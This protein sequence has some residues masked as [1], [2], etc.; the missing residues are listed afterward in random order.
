M[1][2]ILDSKQRIMDVFVTNEGR[3]QAAAGEFSIRYATFT[4]RHTFYDTDNGL[5]PRPIASDATNR[6]F[7]ECSNRRQDQIVV[8]TLSGGA[9]KPFRSADFDLTPSNNS[10]DSIA[11]SLLPFS[12]NK[13]F[14]IL[15]S[16]LPLAGSTIKF[17]DKKGKTTTIMFVDRPTED[18]QI[19][20]GGLTVA[21]VASE[22]SKKIKNLAALNA[23]FSSEV[24]D[25]ILIV[26][27]N[28]TPA[29]NFDPTIES[30]TG[31]IEKIFVKQEGS[32]VVFE[33]AGNE[34]IQDIT[35]NFLQQ[36]ILGS[37]DLFS[38]SSDF[39]VN[40][41]DQK[42]T[43]TLSDT[44]PFK[45]NDLK[46]LPLENIESIFQDKRFSHLPNFAYLPPR[47]KPLLGERQGSLLGNYVNWSQS[48]PG[49]LQELMQGLSNR[50]SIDIEFTETSR[51]NNLLIQ[52]FEFVK[53]I[54]I[55]KLCIVDYGEFP[56][57]DVTSPG[58]RVFYVGKLFKDSNDFDTFINIFTVIMD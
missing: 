18:Y 52:P 44:Q 54:G 34:F 28:T 55:R 6:I 57:E 40:T 50:E 1:A 19:A 5:E 58:K 51:D 15:F 36:E 35:D 24:T 12:S 22:V 38:D 20:I 43:F 11:S 13:V 48:S 2:G 3:A 9:I 31:A 56:D 49:N 21:G 33:N 39:R 30:F 25:N 8:E 46:E 27:A 41:E 17:T 45:Q 47:N 7:F 4:D 42:I 10:V 23:S 26:T 53:D 29:G 16:A 37:Y 14:K 32:N